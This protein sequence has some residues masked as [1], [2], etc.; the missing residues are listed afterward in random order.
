MAEYMSAEI[1]IG[2]RIPADK[3]DGLI[4]AIR[5]DGPSL[6]WS[7][8]VFKPRRAR[9][10]MAA[11]EHN[12]ID[13]LTLNDHEAY[14]GR[15]DRIEAYCVEQGISFDRQTDAKNEFNGEKRRFRFGMGDFEFQS[16]QDGFEVVNRDQL[17]EVRDELR[18]GLYVNALKMLEG[19]MGPDVPDLEPFSVEGVETISQEK[20]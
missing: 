10:L 16:D 3:V 13:H 1:V 9:D 11:I 14:Y 8:G 19:F 5:A 4:K 7:C 6:D 18:R 20:Q 12:G 2:G 15:F 17:I